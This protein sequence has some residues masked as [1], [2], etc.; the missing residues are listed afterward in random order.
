MNNTIQ[1]P[2]DFIGLYQLE[3]K[4]IA[5]GIVEFYENNPN[6]H[7]DAV[8]GAGK[9]NEIVKSRDI[10]LFISDFVSDEH[11]VFFKLLNYLK[12]SFNHYKE[13]MN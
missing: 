3:D 11:E 9:N 10:S 5:P 7:H 13:N 1:E 12:V 4:T 2:I 6:L 8:S